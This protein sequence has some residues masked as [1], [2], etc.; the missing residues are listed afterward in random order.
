MAE[1]LFI[2]AFNISRMF[3]FQRKCGHLIIIL[4]TIKLEK[5]SIYLLIELLNKVTLKK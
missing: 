5:N 1:K 4:D 3:R 2:D